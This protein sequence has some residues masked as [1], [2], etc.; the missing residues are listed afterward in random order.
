MPTQYFRRG[1][2]KNT[3][4]YKA[5]N[6]SV[7]IYSTNKNYRYKRGGVV[8][9]TGLSWGDCQ[10]IIQEYI[11]GATKK[12]LCECHGISYYYLKSVLAMPPLYG[13]RNLL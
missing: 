12:S 1:P 6:G 7:R 13:R 8:R 4:L 9:G 2:N 11:Q 10:A 5:K 3:A